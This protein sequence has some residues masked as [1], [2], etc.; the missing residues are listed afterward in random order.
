M[1][2][3]LTLFSI[4]VL[5]AVSAF[6]LDFSLRPGGFV[7]FPAGPGN[8]AADGNERFDIGGGGELGF[9]I[10]FAGIWP[11]PLGLG[12][13]AGIE[14]GLLYNPYKSPA[15]GNVQTY[16]F[17]G[18]LGLY[19]FP[20]SRLFTR[21]DGGI[22][23]YQSVIEEG[24]GK[25]GLW[26]RT[27]GAA[28]FRFTPTFTL[29]AT[30]GWRQYQNAGGGVFNSGFYT[31]LALHINFT[32]GKS[33]NAGGAAAALV[34]DDGVY[35]AFLS[36]Y[37]Q[38]PAGTITIR[39]DENAEIRDVRVSFRAAGYTASEFPCG[40][41]PL[42]AKGRSAALP[43]YADFS[44][45]VLRFTDTGRILGEV[46]IRYRFLGTEKQSVQT[47]AVQVHNRNVFAVLA[48]RRGS[49]SERRRV[50]NVDWTRLTAFVSPASPEVLEYAKY[51]TGLA[52]SNRRTGLNQNMQFAVWLFEGLRASGI[53]LAS[54]LQE[55]DSLSASRSSVFLEVQFP[56]ETLGFRTGNRR[57]IGLLCT[58]VLEASGIPSAIIPLDDDFI[59]ACNIGVSQSAAELLFNGLEKVLLIDGQVWMP[60]SMNA[61]NEGF[62]AA[63]AGG[64]ETLNKVFADG[65]EADFIMPENAWAIYPPAPL[66][67]QGTAPVRVNGGN[68]AQVSDGVI[69]QYI[70]QEILP[71]A[72]ALQRQ[73]AA[74]PTA[75]LYNRLGILLIRSGR[76]A[77]AR[78]AYERAAG[79]GL[80]PAMANRGNLA[81]IEKDYPAAE[82]WF[83]E[84][85]EREPENRTALRGMEQIGEREE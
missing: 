62:M 65:T 51:V 54:P 68:L 83:K 1:N 45:E 85:L 67:A 43:L 55:D 66:P 76:T 79:M 33:S 82:R 16:A 20:L 10:D 63:W 52:R 47:V 50:E 77:E 40:T 44:P 72:E 39:N 78:S 41:L 80:V 59:V 46:V 57:D 69:Q 32:A 75:A 42:I 19:Y 56:S 26:W 22:G 15:S 4:L 9:D 21:V 36:L 53:R 60:L 25:P 27:G 17:G 38:N 31:G 5:T 70:R 23:V 2:K 74:S 28:G 13:T 35:P 29:A 3:W 7:F 6:T 61:F 30:G 73:I 48:Q 64:V 71:Q 8:K 58:A 14:G 34:Q 84:V 24:K 49:G 37:Q 12:Y 11:N 81:I 18:A